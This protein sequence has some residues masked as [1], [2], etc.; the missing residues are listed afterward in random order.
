[1]S[2]DPRDASVARVEPPPA[3]PEPPVDES[4]DVGEGLGVFRALFLILIFYA[5]SGLLIWFAWHAWRH[6]HSR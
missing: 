6:W 5:A 1:M 4:C 3:D 2:I